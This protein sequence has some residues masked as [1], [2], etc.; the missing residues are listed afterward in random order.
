[1]VLQEYSEIY[2]HPAQRIAFRRD[3]LVNN[4]ATM[5]SLDVAVSVNWGSI[6]KGF[7]AP[8]KG[9]GVD[10]AQAES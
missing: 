9:F 4:T 3:A 7:G 10:T 6:S 5:W 1:M 8:L 2:G